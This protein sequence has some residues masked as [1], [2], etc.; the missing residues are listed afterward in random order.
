MTRRNRNMPISTVEEFE[1][2]E[3]KVK[4]EYWENDTT[5]LPYHV[6]MCRWYRSII[7]DLLDAPGKKFE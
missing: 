1:S 4:D 2:E 5:D 3:Q 6:R 7:L